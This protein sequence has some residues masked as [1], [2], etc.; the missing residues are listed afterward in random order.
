MS[1]SDEQDF[2]KGRTKDKTVASTSL[3][4]MGILLVYYQV[5]CLIILGSLSSLNYD[6]AEWICSFISFDIELL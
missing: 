5:T 2:L 6:K 1:S 3:Q 4:F